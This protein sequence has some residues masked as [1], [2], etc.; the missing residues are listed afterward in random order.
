M[1]FPLSCAKHNSSCLK[2]FNWRKPHDGNRE[3][4]I[5]VSV[6]VCVKHM[7]NNALGDYSRFHFIIRT[8]ARPLR[9]FFHSE[10]LYFAFEVYICHVVGYQWPLSQVYTYPWDIR[11]H[12]KGNC[13]FIPWWELRYSDTLRDSHGRIF[14]LLSRNCETRLRFRRRR[15]RSKVE[16]SRFR[17][18]INIS[19]FRFVSCAEFQS[20]FDVARLQYIDDVKASHFHAQCCTSTFPFPCDDIAIFPLEMKVSAIVSENSEIGALILLPIPVPGS[21]N[22]IKEK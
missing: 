8:Y 1:L 12:V 18:C 20:P 5:T 22:T 21:S 11:N 17:E 4:L 19:R 14:V 16:V 2:F 13:C 7:Y 6:C 15:V 3:K 10:F 9:D